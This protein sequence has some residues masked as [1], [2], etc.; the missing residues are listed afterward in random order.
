MS[1]TLDEVLAVNIT[2]LNEQELD[3]HKA[4]VL[5]LSKEDIIKYLEHLIDDEYV[6]NDDDTVDKNHPNLVKFLKDKDFK[7]FYDVILKED[8]D[9]TIE[10]NQ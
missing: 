10:E 6:I 1:K 3:A 8:A 7:D 4:E 9:E 2:V 5:S